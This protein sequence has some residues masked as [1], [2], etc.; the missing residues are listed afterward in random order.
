MIALPR[1]RKPS[2]T[3]GAGPAFHEVELKF[4]TLRPRRLTML[5]P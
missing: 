4:R 1:R 2:I 3:S 5:M